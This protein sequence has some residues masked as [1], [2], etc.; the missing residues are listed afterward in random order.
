MH[1]LVSPAAAAPAVRGAV[2]VQRA[3][4]DGRYA[5]GRAFARDVA[6]QQ[7]SIRALDNG[8]VTGVFEE[9]DSLWR[10]TPFAMAGLTQFGPMFVLERLGAE[11]GL[12]VALRVEHASRADGSLAHSFEGAPETIALA[13]ALGQRSVD[14]PALVAMLAT[15]CGPVGAKR[16]TC[17]LVSSGAG[18][19]LDVPSG[20]FSRESIIHYYTPHTIREGQ[21]VPLDGPLFSWVLAPAV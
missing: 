9:L 8:D 21:P 10:A 1:G 11:Y 18:P 2:P 6:L 17:T 4:F 15:R 7:V 19:V 16:A 20:A 14:W 5:E 3:I 13:E 12:R